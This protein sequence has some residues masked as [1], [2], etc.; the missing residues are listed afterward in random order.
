MQHNN[1]CKTKFF[2]LKNGDNRTVTKAW[3][4]EMQNSTTGQA[5]E[6]TMTPALYRR[7]IYIDDT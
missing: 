5:S 4:Q 6:I 3:R 2:E 1:T 7:T